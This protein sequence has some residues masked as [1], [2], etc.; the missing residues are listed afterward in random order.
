MTSKILIICLLLSF[1]I[2]AKSISSHPIPEHITTI[3]VKIV[4]PFMWCVMHPFHHVQKDTV[5]SAVIKGVRGTNKLVIILTFIGIF[6]FIALTILVL[7]GRHNH[8][9]L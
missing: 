6:I 8:K 5:D 1:N 7:F 9:Y 4:H 3:E 2:L